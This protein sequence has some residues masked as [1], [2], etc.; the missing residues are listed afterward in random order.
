[1]APHLALISKLLTHPSVDE[2][3]N[4]CLPISYPLLLV[5]L[6]KGRV[7]SKLINLIIKINTAIMLVSVSST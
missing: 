6:F 3:T 1:M 4:E 5:F 7:L 2:G